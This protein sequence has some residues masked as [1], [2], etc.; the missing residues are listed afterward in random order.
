MGGAA[1]GEEAADIA[2]KMLTARL[3]R[4]TG[5]TADRIR[6]AIAVANNEI[7]EAAARN[8][9]WQGMACVLTVAVVEDGR[10]VVGHVG[11]SRL[12]LLRP[13]EIRKITHDHSPVGQ[14]EDRGEL[15][16]AEAMRH[17]RR[18]EVFR[19]VGSAPHRPSDADFIEITEVPLAP[20]AALLLCSDGLSDLVTSAEIRKTVEE[21]AGDPQA[22]VHALIAAANSAGGK[23]NVTAVLVEG[24][25]YAATPVLAATG[26]RPSR[27]ALASRW[28]FL[29]YG[30]VAAAM[31]LLAARLVVEHAAHRPGAEP[32][33]RTWH[34]GP[35]QASDGATI[36]SV[37]EKAQPGDTVMVDPGEYRELVR[38]RDGIKLLSRDPH[39][40]VLHATDQ[41]AALVVEGVRSGRIGGFKI[42]GD[43]ANPLSVGVAVR[44]SSVVLDYLLITGAKTA[45][46]EIAGEGAPVV[47]SSQIVNNSGAGVIVRAGAAPQLVH[48]TI[49]GNGKAPRALRP[50]L[51]MEAGTRPALEGNTFFDNGA[52]AIWAAA[53][54]PDPAT[55][56]RLLAGNFFGYPEKGTPRRRVRVI[57]R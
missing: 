36:S 41:G 46:L 57:T 27:S 24:P 51:E 45:G 8:P 28:A 55:L 33:A 23:D 10:A 1:A 15:T 18:N 16:E 17:P 5:T 22:G 53:P 54:G 13:G 9:E 52:E 29:V 21:H 26:E 7:Y 47:R 11:D 37:L 3:G 19:D 44:R 39:A 34:V 50:G 48:N 4:Q 6:E 56:A 2:L 42:V 31:A 14:R 30:A 32:A 25:Q 43:D 20:D 38:A 49:A 35:G 12:Y 40:A